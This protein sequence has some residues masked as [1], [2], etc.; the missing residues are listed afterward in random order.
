M[1]G[2]LALLG[3]ALAFGIGSALLPMFLNAELYVVSMG[4]LVSGS[5][6]AFVIVSLV[7]GTVIGKAFVFEVA[8][9]GTSRIRN[10]ERRPSQR[11]V[12]VGMRRLADRLRIREISDWLLGLID[13]PYVGA[14]T[15]FVS[16]LIGVPPLAVVTLV[17]GASSQPR[18]LFLLMVFIGRFM[19]FLVIGYL[20]HAAF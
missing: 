8:R 11:R 18:W 7:V 19:Q 9:R 1:G 16:S 12:V 3:A 2:D 14:L 5:I 4:A 17:A 6:L 10:V 15:V 20:V 13:R